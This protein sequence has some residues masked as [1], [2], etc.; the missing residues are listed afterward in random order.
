MH[1]SRAPRGGLADEGVEALAEREAARA[2]LVEGRVLDRVVV[3]QR[4][5]DDERRLVEAPQ[6]RLEPGEAL[7]VAAAVGD[8]G[9]AEGGIGAGGE[10]VDEGGVVVVGRA[11]RRSG[12]G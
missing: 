7:E 12:G 10:S 4:D 11:R 5:V 2:H 3:E 8:D 6:V 1:G 9:D